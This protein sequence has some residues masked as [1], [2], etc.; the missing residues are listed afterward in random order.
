MTPAPVAAARNTNIVAEGELIMTDEELQQEIQKVCESIDNL[1]KPEKPLPKGEKRRREVLLARKEVLYQ[2]K[3][4]KEKNDKSR[5]LTNNI[6]YALLTSL[7]EKHPYLL[8]F[9]RSQIRWSA[10]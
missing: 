4:A 5:E 9:M 10:I 1:P 2:I 3:D 6:D 8:Y 7:G